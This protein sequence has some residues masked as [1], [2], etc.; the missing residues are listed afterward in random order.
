MRPHNI[1]IEVR[2]YSRYSVAQGRNVAAKDAVNGGFDFIFFVD[3]DQ[4]LPCDTLMKLL[5]MEGDVRLAWTIMNVG[6]PETNIAIYDRE[7]KHFTF[8]SIETLPKENVFEADGGGL[9]VSLINT[10]LFNELEYPYFRYIEYA[11]GDTLSEDL[12]FCLTIKELDKSIKC[13]PALKVGHI[14]HIVI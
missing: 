10:G 3:S 11:N 2:T 5:S 7:K 8:H 12:N 6:R 9:A 4:V 13:D 1:I 14:K